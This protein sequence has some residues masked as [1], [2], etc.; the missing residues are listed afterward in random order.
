MVPAA[1]AGLINVDK[2]I[3]EDDDILSILL[4]LDILFPLDNDFTIVLGILYNIALY[5]YIIV[6]D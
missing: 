6:V 2:V 1:I 5:N 4:G 3:D